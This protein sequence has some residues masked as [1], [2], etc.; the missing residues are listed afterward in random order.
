MGKFKESDRIND[1]FENIDFYYD[2]FNCNECGNSGVENFILTE[3]LQTV[4]Y[5]FVK[6]VIKNF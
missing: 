4:K 5:G 1:F 3:L 6:N 2:S